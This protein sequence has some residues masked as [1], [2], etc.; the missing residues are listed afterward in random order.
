MSEIPPH[1]G[2]DEFRAVIADYKS[3][4]PW[5]LGGTVLVPLVDYVLRIGPPWPNGIAILTSIAELLVLI[6]VFHFWSTSGYRRVSRRMVISIVLLVVFGGVYLYLS[7]SYTFT[8][9]ASSDRFVKGIVPRPE[10]EPLLTPKFTADDALRSSGYNPQAVWTTASITAM[11]L[12]LLS[13]WLVSFV[14]LSTTIASFVIY[15][16]RRHAR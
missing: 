6:C 3:I 13:L 1:S 8:A 12:I 16:R 11:R 7:S 15:Y 2:L 10:V 9:G 14:F 4:G 5:V